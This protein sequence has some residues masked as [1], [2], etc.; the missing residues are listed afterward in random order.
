MKNLW[1]IV[2]LVGIVLLFYSV[3]GR[4]FGSNTL[5]GAYLIKWTSALLV[6]QSLM[7]IAVLLKLAASE[8]NIQK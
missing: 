3:V 8:K 7:L 2:G 4:F 1:K 6:S 5:G